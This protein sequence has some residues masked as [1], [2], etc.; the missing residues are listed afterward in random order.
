MK[1]VVLQLGSL[2]EWDEGP[3][4]SKYTVLPYYN[5]DNKQALLD[6][7][8]AT[9]KA[10]VT[11]GEIGADKPL[12]DACPAL[13]LITVYGVGYDAVAVND[14]AKRGIS[15]TN[16]PDVLTGDVADLGVAMLLCARRNMLSA[17]DWVRSNQWKS[18]GNHALSTRVFGQRTGILGLGRIG[19]EIATRLAGFNMTIYYH[20]ISPQPCAPEWHYVDSPE[21]LAKQVDNLF[22]T[23]AASADTRHI[24]D[25]QVIDALGTDGLLLNVSRASNID[26]NALLNALESGTLGAAALDVFENEPGIDPRWLALDNV[27]LQPH[28]ASATTQTRQAMGKLVLDNLAAHFAG[29]PLLTPVTLAAATEAGTEAN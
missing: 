3:L 12:L 10:I 14:C 7:H 5:T 21:Q 26:E 1:P 18:K 2:P 28:H 6:Q 16:T 22:V 23:L 15:V 9:V 8:G 13:E 17:S 24:V 20:D 29:K 19:Y 25:R 11:R 27:L 4:H